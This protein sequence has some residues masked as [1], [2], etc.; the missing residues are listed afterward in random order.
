MLI[1][2]RFFSFCGFVCRLSELEIVRLYVWRVDTG[3]GFAEREKND[4]SCRLVALT[5]V[6]LWFIYN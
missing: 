2:S 6:R 4:F 1:L 5:F 3:F